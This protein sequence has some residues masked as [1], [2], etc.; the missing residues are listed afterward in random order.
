LQ[1]YLY[2]RWYRQDA[3]L[4]KSF[5]A[6]LMILEMA[7]A[8]VSTWIAWLSMVQG[9]GD[10]SMLSTTSWSFCVAIILTGIIALA[11][12]AFFAQRL[13]LLSRSVLII[14]FVGLLALLQCACA[15]VGSVQVLFANAIPTSQLSTFNTFAIWLSASAACDVAI[16]TA[17][18]FF[19][20]RSR[21]AIHKTTDDLIVRL[22]RYSMQTGVPTA[23]CAIVELV[24][25]LKFRTNNLQDALFLVLAKLYSNA[26]LA[27]LN[28]RASLRGMDN[29]DACTTGIDW[30]TRRCPN[31]Q[32]RQ[33]DSDLPTHE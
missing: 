25:F 18:V 1:T 11:A 7:D 6:L 24:L 20:C 13:W 27:N 2:Y 22:V 30:R 28:A 15:I 8:V 26:V 32:S 17:M 29:V 19:L 3:I 5:V 4:L 10:L 23:V 14:V 31:C 12:Q 33:V 16:A 21:D 9:W